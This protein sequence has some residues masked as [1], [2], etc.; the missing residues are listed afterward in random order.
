MSVNLYD[1]TVHR[2]IG[3]G[4]FG[5]VHGCTKADTGKMYALKFLNKKRLKAKR[6]EYLARD[7]KNMLSLVSQGVSIFCPMSFP[8]LTII[9]FPLGRLSIHHMH[10]ILLPNGGQTVSHH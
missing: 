6:C 5:E 3:K 9:Y 8:T 7:E 2:I 1:F 10:D 4:G